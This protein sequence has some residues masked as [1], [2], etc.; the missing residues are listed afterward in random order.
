MAVDR[1][2]CSNRLSCLDTKGTFKMTSTNEI[3]ESNKIDF[4]S[5]L[6]DSEELI[7]FCLAALENV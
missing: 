1:A 2:S 3:C 4:E 5:S 7:P 6:F